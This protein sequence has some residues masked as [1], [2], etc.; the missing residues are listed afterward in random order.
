MA[1]DLHNLTNLL[2]PVNPH[3]YSRSLAE[4]DRVRAVGKL[5]EIGVARKV[6]SISRRHIVVG[7][8]VLKDIK[9]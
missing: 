9:L 2:V 3:F 4:P 1:T 5:L 8:C 7:N 6:S